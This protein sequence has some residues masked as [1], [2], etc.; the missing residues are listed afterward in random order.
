MTFCLFER[1]LH[2]HGDF[3]GVLGVPRS[4]DDASMT[5]ARTIRLNFVNLAVSFVLE[6][7][8]LVKVA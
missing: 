5:T 4:V 6:D 1:L 2:S 3:N 8:L 7:F